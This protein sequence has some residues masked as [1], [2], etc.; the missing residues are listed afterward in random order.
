MV[1][2]LYDS[3]S[4]V[5]GFFGEQKMATGRHRIQGR[6]GETFADHGIG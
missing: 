4:P 1:L 5:L 3:R 6:D 2:T